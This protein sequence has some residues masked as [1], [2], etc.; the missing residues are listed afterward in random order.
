MFLNGADLLLRILRSER[1]ADFQL[2]LNACVKWCLGSG[3]LAGPIM[4]S[5]C[6]SML[7]KWKHLNMN[8]QKHTHHA[9]RWVCCSPVWASK[10]QLCGYWSGT[11]AT[12][13]RRQESGWSCWLHITKRSSHKMVDD[14]T[15]DDSICGCHERALWHWWSEPE[16]TQGAWS[17]Q[18]GQ[19]RKT[20]TEDNGSCRAEAESLW[21]W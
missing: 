12:I 1:E 3:L 6:Q 21:S 4:A 7:Q 16:S 18:N 11:G 14:K 2:H 15:C 17:I 10:L 13:N 20:H 5:T 8:N 19:R 9:A